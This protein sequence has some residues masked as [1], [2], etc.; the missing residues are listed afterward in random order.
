MAGRSFPRDCGWP[1]PASQPSLLF[2]RCQSSVP[3]LYKYFLNA[4][5]ICVQTSK[6]TGVIKIFKMPG[7]L[8]SVWGSRSKKEE[9]VFISVDDMVGGERICSV[10]NSCALFSFPHIT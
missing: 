9:F 7:F 2:K 6:T 3:P 10:T 8:L 5:V 1:S 4:F